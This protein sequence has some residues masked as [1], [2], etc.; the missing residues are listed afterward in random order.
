MSR[1]FVVVVEKVERLVM[2]MGLWRRW[3]RFVSRR[4][5]VLWENRPGVLGRRSGRRH[6]RE[7]RLLESAAKCPSR[8]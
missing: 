7:A 8:R 2:V 3:R 6:E 5:L 4:G 1:S